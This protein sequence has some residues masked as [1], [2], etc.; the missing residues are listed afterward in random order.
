MIY[1]VDVLLFD[2]FETLDV[3]GP[4][5]ILG[6]LPDIFKLNFISIDG[7]ITESSQKVRVETN[8]YREEKDSERI[9]IVP[10]GN[11]TRENVD[12]ESFISLIKE[13]HKLAKYT[14]SV[15]TGSA[16]LAKAGILHSKRATTNKKA[17]KWVTEQDEKVIWVKE[18][19]W[20]KDGNIYTSSGVSAGMD[21]TLGF[22][23]D[24]L[25]KEKA[26]D[27]SRRI[28]YIWNEDSSYDPFSKLYE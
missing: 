2:D 17:Y 6:K 7:G 20:V 26:L 4:V 1:L 8:L 22:I 19:R 23:E 3:F 25:G 28:E 13:L 18:A 14:L 10:G 21:M 16:L 11:G 12:D 5:E 9:L 24:L 15:C 27:T